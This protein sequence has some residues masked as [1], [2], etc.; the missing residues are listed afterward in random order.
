MSE[1]MGGGVAGAGGDGQGGG[2]VGRGTPSHTPT[3]R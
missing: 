2:Q 3:P 1:D